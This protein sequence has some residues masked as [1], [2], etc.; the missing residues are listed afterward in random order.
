MLKKRSILTFIKAQFSAFF[1]GIVD[2]LVMIGCTE[3]LHIHY[4][5][6]IVVGGFI[7]AIV[8]FTINRNWTFEAKGARGKD[9]LT[10]QVL[11]FAS[12]VGGSILLK[13][14]G[15][16]LLTE[17][18]RIDYKVSRI[19]VDI[20]VSLGFNYTLQRYWVFKKNKP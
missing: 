11:K 14:T 12:M 13:S 8:N 15:T 19:I 17:G 6:S 9:E 2:Y 7:G 10:V 18:V 20:M 5:I 16:Y 1:G 3:L 4:T